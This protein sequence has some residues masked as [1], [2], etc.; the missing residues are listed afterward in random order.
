MKNK[1]AEPI[2]EVIGGTKE[3]REALKK[4]IAKE[5]D[6]KLIHE[7]NNRRTQA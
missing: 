3:W 2:F 4:K 6:P 5:L 7:R 1:K